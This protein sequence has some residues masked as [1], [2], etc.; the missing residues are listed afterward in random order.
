MY[1]H[2]DVAQQMQRQM[3]DE[4]QQLRCVYRV[5]ALNRARRK[6]AR[7]ERQM[8]RARTDATRLR[9]QLEAEL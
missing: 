8:R 7:A 9:R 6:Q 1:L 3:L 4:A 5:S 2:T